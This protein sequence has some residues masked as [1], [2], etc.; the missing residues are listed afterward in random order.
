MWCFCAEMNIIK[1]QRFYNTTYNEYNTIVL[2]SVLYTYNGTIEASLMPF[3]TR[4]YQRRH[5]K[6]RVFRTNCTICVLSIP[7]FITFLLF[8]YLNL[9][10]KFRYYNC[11]MRLQSE[12]AKSI[13]YCFTVVNLVV[14]IR[15]KYGIHFYGM[16][17]RFSK[18]GC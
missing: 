17:L 14:I 8:Y 10:F 1:G 7:F 4:C 5:G 15:R 12:L 16:L 9:F 18:T 11:S 13:N 2:Y 6:C 3:Q